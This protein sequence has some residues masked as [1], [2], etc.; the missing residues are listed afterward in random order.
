[1]LFNHTSATS[2]LS[3]CKKYNLKK[4]IHAN[5]VF[6]SIVSGVMKQQMKVPLTQSAS[7]LILFIGTCSEPDKHCNNECYQVTPEQ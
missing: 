2:E 7:A 1:M 3:F 5:W 4:Y 6:S